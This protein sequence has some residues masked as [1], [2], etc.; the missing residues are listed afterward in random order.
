MSR[1]YRK[2]YVRHKQNPKD[3]KLAAKRVRRKKID[4]E[5]GDGKAYKKE[6]NSWDIQDW[7]W[8]NPDYEEGK[9]K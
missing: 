9:K 7:G 3:K 2:P 6:S 4:E 5:I 1:S 8:Y